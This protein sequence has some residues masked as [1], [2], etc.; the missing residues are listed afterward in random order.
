MTKIHYSTPYQSGNIGRALNEFCAMVPDGD[1]ICLRDQDTLLFD[2]SGGLIEDIVSE[3]KQYALIGSMT[4]RLAAPDQLVKGMFDEE[5]ITK[6]KQVFLDL[7][8]FI[9]SP[10]SHVLAGVFMLFPKA[11]WEMV[12]GFTEKSIHF[13][14]IFTTD[15]R[16]K[17]GKVGLATGLY[18]FHL[19][20]WGKSNP[21][22]SIS[23]LKNCK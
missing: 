11:T 3:N 1:W 14:K 5:N 9:V 4:N 10:V 13:D 15:V 21:R 2:G 17:G 20:R 8:S 6:H 23:H 18:V 22:L 7:F 12:G 16:R 19:Y